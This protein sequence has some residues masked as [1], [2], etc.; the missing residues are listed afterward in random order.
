MDMRDKRPVRF[1]LTVSCLLMLPLANGERLS[2]NNRTVPQPFTETSCTLEECLRDAEQAYQTRDFHALEAAARKA[3][4]RE[5]LNRKARY[6]LG[7]SLAAQRRNL[8]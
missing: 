8:A 5:K 2:L 3:L 7:V 6:Y 4:R 1:I